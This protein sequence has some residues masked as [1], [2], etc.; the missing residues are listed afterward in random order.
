MF[1]MFTLFFDIN[2]WNKRF[3]WKY[4]FWFGWSILKMLWW[5]YVWPD[6][7]LDRR[8]K[9]NYFKV[10]CHS[11]IISIFSMCHEAA[12]ECLKTNTKHVL[13]PLIDNLPNHPTTNYWVIAETDN[14]VKA[15][16]LCVKYARILKKTGERKRAF[17]IFYIVYCKCLILIIKNTLLQYRK[18]KNFVNAT[19]S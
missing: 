13:Y 11:N 8:V 17:W 3:F 19:D 1:P 15:S 14:H 2:L 18:T 4:D 5:T 10:W 16:N 7:Y 12:L 6:L 9:K